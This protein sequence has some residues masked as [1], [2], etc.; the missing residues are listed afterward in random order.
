MNS[1]DAAVKMLPLL[2]LSYSILFT[3]DLHHS[4][5]RKKKRRNEAQKQQHDVLRRKHNEEHKKDLKEILDFHNRYSVFADVVALVVGKEDPRKMLTKHGKELKRLV[6][7]L[8]D[9]KLISRKRTAK[10]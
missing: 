9:T 8:E 4:I 5:E 3:S 10:S 6:I 2:S 7:V 1:N